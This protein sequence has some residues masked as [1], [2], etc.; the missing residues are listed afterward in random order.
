MPIF[1]FQCAKGHVTAELLSSACE[2]VTCACG[3]KAKRI[4]STFMTAYSSSFE[5][6]DNMPPLKRQMLQRHQAYIESR[7]DDVKSG[8]LKI[9]EAGPK[10]LRPRL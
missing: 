6:V 5:D 3:R 2:F 7:K 1:E 8:K 4:P 10:V 9:K